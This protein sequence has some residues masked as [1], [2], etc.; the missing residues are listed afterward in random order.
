MYWHPTRLLCLIVRWWWRY[1][2]D[3]GINWAFSGASLQSWYRHR[4]SLYWVISRGVRDFP[5]SV[6]RFSYS[7]HFWSCVYISC[8]PV[9]T[10]ETKIAEQNRWFVKFQ[11]MLKC[12][13]YDQYPFNGKLGLRYILFSWNLPKEVG[14]VLVLLWIATIWAKN[15]LRWTLR[16]SSP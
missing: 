1:Q 16:M 2:S 15:L 9:L 6:S 12:V 4:L 14:G 3:V 8:L 11:K 5:S 10:Y 13:Q 7:C